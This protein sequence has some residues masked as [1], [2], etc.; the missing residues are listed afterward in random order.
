MQANSRSVHSPQRGPHRN[1]PALVER[2]LRHRGRAPLAAH[3]QRA[4]GLLREAIDGA[5]VPLIVDSFCGTG[6]STA[7][8]AAAHPEHFVVGIDQSAHRLGKHEPGLGDNYLLLQAQCEPIWQLLAQDS[9][10]VEQHYLLYPNPWPKAG[11]LK[12]RV[13]GCAGFRDLVAL[14]SRVELRSNW[15]IYVEEFGLAMHLAGRRGVVSEHNPDEALSLFEQKY[16]AS[17]QRL[18]T[19]RSDCPARLTP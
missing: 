16:Q 10:A 19:Y 17:G 4:Y 12:R 7:M 1:L 13:H 9:V 15:P 3:N 2:H 5:N 14:A 8:L 6:R 18:W 11:Q